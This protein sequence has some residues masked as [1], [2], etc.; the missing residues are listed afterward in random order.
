M[1]VFDLTR[2]R[3]GT[4][5]MKGKLFCFGGGGMVFLPFGILVYCLAFLFYSYSSLHLYRS[6]LFA[7]ILILMG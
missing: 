5:A 2:G 6:F 7:I 4:L 1:F 3:L